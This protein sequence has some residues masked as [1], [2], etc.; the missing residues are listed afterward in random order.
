MEEQIMGKRPLMI[1][2]GIVG[3]ALVGVA[4][5]FL[6]KGEDGLVPPVPPEADFKQ[7]SVV[8]EYF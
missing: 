4:A 2:A 6:L 7:G 1:I 3:L 5:Y 8:V